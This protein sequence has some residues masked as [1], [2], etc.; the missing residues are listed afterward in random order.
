[1]GTIPFTRVQSSPSAIMQQADRGLQRGD[2]PP[3]F[4]G[5]R[6]SLTTFTPPGRGRRRRLRW[7]KHSA[8]TTSIIDADE[9]DIE[10]GDTDAVLSD[11]ENIA[12]P[13]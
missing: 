1:M 4:P 10:E 3:P 7:E 2:L 5:R 13:T 11:E 12:V 9:S 6:N 8:R